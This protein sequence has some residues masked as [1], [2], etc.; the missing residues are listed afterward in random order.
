MSDISA[1]SNLTRNS[2]L[3]HRL[4]VFKTLALCPVLKQCEQIKVVPDLHLKISFIEMR[5]E[6]EKI[7]SD[8]HLISRQIGIKH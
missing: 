5:G 4:N 2:F 6:A 8:P 7:K 1:Y 3:L